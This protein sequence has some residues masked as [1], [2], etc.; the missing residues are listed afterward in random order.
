MINVI[1][2]NLLIEYLFS[3]MPLELSDLYSTEVNNGGCKKVPTGLKVPPSNQTSKE[4][5]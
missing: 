3:N 1:E 2:L 4:E 5:W